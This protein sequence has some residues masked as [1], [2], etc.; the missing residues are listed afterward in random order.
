MLPPIQSISGSSSLA[1]LN[2]ISAYV[3]EFDR[4]LGSLLLGTDPTSSLQ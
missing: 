4:R 1:S 3:Q 2:I